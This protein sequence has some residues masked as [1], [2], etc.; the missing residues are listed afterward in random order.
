MIPVKRNHMFREGSKNTMRIFSHHIEGTPQDSHNATPS[1][2]PRPLLTKQ[3]KRNVITCLLLV[4]TAAS[5]SAIDAHASETSNQPASVTS[6]IPKGNIP[7]LPVKSLSSSGPFDNSAAPPTSDEV[8]GAPALSV[9]GSIPSSSNFQ[10][11][12]NDKSIAVPQ[13]GSMSQSVPAADGSGQTNISITNTHSSDG[14]AYSHSFSSISSS[15]SGST[16]VNVR[17]E[18]SSP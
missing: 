17:S 5:Y 1:S 16:S 4:V 9:G 8:L 6:L 2:M 14:N 15:A 3:N 13:N 10:V 12:V 7:S 11:T 18:H